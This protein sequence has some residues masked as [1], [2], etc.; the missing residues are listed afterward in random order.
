V[1]SLSLAQNVFEP[2]LSALVVGFQMC[3]L[4]GVGTNAIALDVTLFL[5][6]SD[7]FVVH[8]SF[9]TVLGAAAVTRKSVS[10]CSV[11]DCLFKLTQSEDLNQRY[12]RL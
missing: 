7:G 4:G 11:I 8:G 10:A 5:G 12:L 1:V 2:K 9:E 3:H 6:E